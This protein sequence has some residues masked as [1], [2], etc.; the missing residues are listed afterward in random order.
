MKLIV[1]SLGEIT[2][3]ITIHAKNEQGELYTVIVR[4]FNNYVYVSCES[5]KNLMS[6]NDYKNTRVFIERVQQYFESIPDARYYNEDI[7]YNVK[8]DMIENIEVVMRKNGF[9]FH[10]MEPHVRLSLPNDFY[11]K[12]LHKQLMERDMVPLNSCINSARQFASS[13]NIVGAG[14]FEV[15]SYINIPSTH[16]ENCIFVDL[17]DIHSLI[18]M[19]DAIPNYRWCTLD[20]EMLEY[21]DGIFVKG[22]RNPIIQMSCNYQ[23]FH[24]GKVQKETASYV[25]RRSG[26]LKGTKCYDFY[27]NEEREIDL[28][29]SYFDDLV[30]KYELSCFTD[31]LPEFYTGLKLQYENVNVK[32]FMSLVLKMYKWKNQCNVQSNVEKYWKCRQFILQHDPSKEK[33]FFPQLYTFHRLEMIKKKKELTSIDRQWFDWF[34]VHENYDEDEVEMLFDFNSIKKTISFVSTEVLEQFLTFVRSFQVTKKEMKHLPIIIGMID[35]V[36]V[37]GLFADEKNMLLKFRDDFLTFDPDVV[38]GYNINTF[39]LPYLLDS[40]E[41]LGIPPFNFSLGRPVL[42]RKNIKIYDDTLRKLKDT[43]IE[44]ELEIDINTEDLN[45]LIRKCKK[46]RHFVIDPLFGKDLFYR[47]LMFIKDASGNNATGKMKDKIITLHGRAVVDVYKVVKGKMKLD[48]YHLKEAAQEILKRT[49]LDVDHSEIPILF[50]GTVEDRLKLRDY[51]KVDVDLPPDI[52]VKKEFDQ[53]MIQLA[54]IAGI[55]LQEVFMSGA[56]RIGVALFSRFFFLMDIVMPS[57]KGKK[58][59]YEGAKVYMSKAGIYRWKIVNGKKVK[60]YILNGDFAGMYPSIMEEFNFC[61]STFI[62]EDV[63]HKLFPSVHPDPNVYEHPEVYKSSSG[64]CFVK[65][66]FDKDGNVIGREGALAKLVE[67]VVNERAKVKAMIAKLGEELESIKQQLKTIEE[68]EEKNVLLTRMKKIEEDIANLKMKE[69]VLKIIANS[70]YGIVG[71]SL[72]KWPLIAVAASVTKEG[73]NLIENYVEK[74]LYEE[75]ES[76]K[77][78]YG[79][80]DSL[81]ITP[82]GASASECWKQICHLCETVNK[83]I[84]SKYIRF[85]PEHIFACSIFAEGQKMY[86][87]L[88]IKDDDD[89]GTLY[90]KGFA[91]QKRSYCD[92]ARKLVKKVLEMILIE[93]AEFDDIFRHIHNIIM[94]LESINNV[95]EWTKSKTTLTVLEKELEITNE[96]LKTIKGE[97]KNVLLKKV[98]KIEEEITSNDINFFKGLMLKAKYG[99]EKYKGTV[100]VSVLQEKNNALKNQ[101]FFVGDTIPYFNV[102]YL[103]HGNRTQNV[104]LADV[105]LSSLDNIDDGNFFRNFNSKILIDTESYIQNQFY[106]PLLKLFPGFENNLRKVF[107]SRGIV[108]IPTYDLSLNI[109]L[110]D[111]IPAVKRTYE[112][113]QGGVVYKKETK[114]EKNF[115]AKQ[116]KLKREGSVVPLTNFIPVVNRKPSFNIMDVLDAD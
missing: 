116:K 51:N 68:G 93:N 26:D 34:V 69:L 109:K 88:K 114:K 70:M 22:D 48:D 37:E 9:G 30:G 13:K 86:A 99:K 89:P 38:S 72:F 81:F 15:S 62:P 74:T 28:F 24:G 84:G 10:E 39:D 66:Q 14:W 41:R 23:I 16:F 12:T 104:E 32:T 52:M 49:K 18:E 40:C 75:Y 71:S 61:I 101:P 87:G 92:N 73:K 60:D 83:K 105:V 102:L 7:N 47:P 96:Q 36:M 6:E 80:T 35:R 77:V 11:V 78:I 20:G 65:R 57:L 85:E 110:Q 17:D 31:S 55:S 106:N 42:S 54:R 107:T 44:E 19:T 91:C 33:W 115:E 64:Y 94:R 59:S 5:F 97:E 112:Q 98:K 43:I 79:D 100:V 58:Q 21:E 27:E 25:L 108:F 56:S 111:V 46:Q 4:K 3:Y 67:M 1:I 63:L 50:S 103:A 2:N 8:R 95:N 82:P 113:M 90:I 53:Q 29:L 45:L 76:A